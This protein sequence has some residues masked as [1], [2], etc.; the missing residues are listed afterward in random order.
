M[1]GGLYRACSGENEHMKQP[2]SSSVEFSPLQW[3]NVNSTVLLD[4]IKRAGIVGMGGAGFPT[5]RKIEISQSHNPCTV[6]VNGVESEPGV[7]ADKTLLDEYP[8]EILDGLQI[9]AKC[10]AADTVHLAVSSFTSASAVEIFA[11]RDVQ[12]H[13]VQSTEWQGEERNLIKVT[14]HRSVDQS[15]YPAELGILVLN[16]ATLFAIHEAVSKGLRPV[17]RMM[18]VNGS[19][20]WVQIA[21]PIQEIVGRSK[22]LR[23]GGPHT[24]F[25]VPS[26]TLTSATTNAIHNSTSVQEMPCIHCG[27]C[28]KICPLTLPVESMFSAS[29]PDADLY[30]FEQALARCFDCGACV[31]VCPS[32]IPVLDGIRSQRQRIQRLKH[33]SESK[34]TAQTRFEQREKRLAKRVEKSNQLRTKRLTSNR[35][36]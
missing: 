24:G 6:L 17:S 4:R 35:K 5:Y 21:K 31:E 18:T 15:I 7:S 2:Q 36:W 32:N 29:L 13:R 33:E 20:E 22:T 23:L 10:I 8:H 11:S 34:E 25:I 3:K 16:V 30:R 9:A 19:N 1:P 26:T 12:V 28:S 27:K 14:L